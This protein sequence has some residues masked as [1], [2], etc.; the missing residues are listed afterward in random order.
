MSK[1][2]VIAGNHE[3]ARTWIKQNITD[4]ANTHGAWRSLSDYITVS[5]PEQLRG[6]SDPHGVFIGNW[7]ERK[8]IREILTILLQSSIS[9][10]TLGDSGITKAIEVYGEYV[11]ENK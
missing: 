6:Y 5:G 11:N 8:D 4:Y 2:F 9:G 3:Q 7:Y 1:T 10:K